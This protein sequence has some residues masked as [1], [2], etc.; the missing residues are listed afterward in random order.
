[1]YPSYIPS[2]KPSVFIQPFRCTFFTDNQMPEI[3]DNNE[4][5]ET[6]IS[7]L[8]IIYNQDSDWIPNKYFQ[9]SFFL[10]GYGYKDNFCPINKYPSSIPYYAPSE[11]LYRYPS[12]LPGVLPPQNPI[13]VHSLVTSLSPSNDPSKNTSN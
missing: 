10:I 9:L 2:Y 12:S 11:S 6:S 1:M 7:L 4:D 13:L 8:S 5:Y 3:I